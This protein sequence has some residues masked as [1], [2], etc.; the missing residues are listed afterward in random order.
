MICPNC[1]CEYLAGVTQCSDCG[2]ALVDALNLTPATPPDL[3][4]IV[5]LWGGNDPGKFAA[6][7]GALETAGIPVMNPDERGHFIFP[8]MRTKMEIA[9]YAADLEKAEKVLIE[10]GEWDDPGELTPEEREALALPES[11]V[12]DGD[13]DPGVPV[14]D[15]GYW[16]DELP[17]TE[18]WKGGEEYFADTLMACFR[19]NGIPSHKVAEAGGWRLEVRPAQEAQAKE[20]VREVVEAR[21]PE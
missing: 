18:V 14:E 3:G 6:V 21:P 16:D 9:V 19:E 2:V 13:E 4:G 12:L 10:L 15:P 11:E 8:S 1:K 5:H 7:K 17:A 20:I